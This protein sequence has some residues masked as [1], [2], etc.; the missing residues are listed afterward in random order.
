[1]IS[2]ALFTALMLA[3]GPASAA[4]IPL[5]I[6]HRVPNLSAPVVLPASC[7]YAGRVTVVFQ[8][9][10]IHACTSVT[11]TAS[12]TYYDPAECWAMEPGQSYPDLL[13]G[14]APLGI[15]FSETVYYPNG[16]WSETE[17]TRWICPDQHCQY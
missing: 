1:M 16:Q 14:C 6:E 12:N 11:A 2:K 8:G 3:G 13:S 15:Q 17:V 4:V 10:T 7:S 9:R 5:L